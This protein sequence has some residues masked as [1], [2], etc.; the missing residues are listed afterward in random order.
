MPKTQ[1]NTLEDLAREIANGRGQYTEQNTIKSA[2]QDTPSETMAAM[3]RPELEMVTLASSSKGNATLVRTP[4]TQV[5]VDCGISARRITQALAELHVDPA[6]LAGVLLTHEHSDHM[7]G[8]AAFLK[9]YPLPVYTTRATFQALGETAVT[10]ARRFVEVT[11]PFTLGDLDVERFAISH[12]AAD[13]GG[14]TFAATRVKAAVCTDLGF[15]SSD[16]EAALRE[17]TLLVLEA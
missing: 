17:A 1:F 14:F 10:Y 15:V 12:D 6:Q 16:V 3:E 7:K 8:L 9:R 13:P 2:A 4:R 11:R 5:L